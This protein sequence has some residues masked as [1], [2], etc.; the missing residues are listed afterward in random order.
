MSTADH[1]DLPQSYFDTVH[2][3]MRLSAEVGTGDDL[4]V[5]YMQFATKTG[6]AQLGPN[7]TFSNTWV[8]G[9][10][11]YNDPEYAFAIVMERRPLQYTLGAQNVARELFDW[12]NVNTPEYFQQTVAVR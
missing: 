2:Q 8:A 5:P 11:P 12:M 4:N 10:F 3:G 1:I 6:T 7:N 9:F